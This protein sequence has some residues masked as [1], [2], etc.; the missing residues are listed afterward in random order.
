MNFF[1]WFFRESLIA[2]RAGATHQEDAVAAVPF[3]AT[4]SAADSRRAV[5]QAH[6]ELELGRLIRDRF[7]RPDAL[8]EAT[9]AAA[10]GSAAA[11]AG[12]SASTEGPSA[13]FA[14]DAGMFA[15]PTPQVTTTAITKVNDA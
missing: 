15:M 7:Q 6:R 2:R 3:R 10:D 14:H 9:A 4:D 12:A 5:A 1:R 8:D 11:A 13:A